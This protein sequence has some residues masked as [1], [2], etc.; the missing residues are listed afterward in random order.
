MALQLLDLPV[1]LL[2]RIMFYL[3]MKSLKA[4]ARV[5]RQL[6][7][8]ASAPVL[9]KHYAMI[10]T[11]MRDASDS[12]VPPDDVLD[13]LNA[14][15]NA[16]RHYKPLCSVTCSVPRNTVGLYELSGGY[17]FLGAAGRRA[18]HYMPLP[19]PSHPTP[20][21]SLLTIGE[22]IVDFALALY[23]H[24]LVVAVTSHP[25]G[26]EGRDVLEIRLIDFPSGRPHPLAKQDRIFLCT[27]P[28]DRHHPFLGIEV[29]GDTMVIAT[30]YS[31]FDD[32]NMPSTL[33]FWD[34]KQGVKKMS[35][36]A[37]KSS[38]TTFI[39]LTEDI[40]LVPNA[41]NGTLEYWRISTT[42][43][44][45]PAPLAVLH[46]PPLRTGVEYLDLACRAEP[47]P[48]ADVPR[49]FPDA[50]PKGARR[51]SVAEQISTAD[52]GRTEPSF[53]PAAED[54]ICVFQVHLMRVMNEANQE[55]ILQ[56][57]LPP[58][59]HLVLVVHRSAF[60][61]ILERLLREPKDAKADANSSAEASSASTAPLTNDSPSSPTTDPAHAEPPSLPWS[62][63][64][65]PVSRWLDYARINYNWITTSC[66]Q[67][68]VATPAPE[69]QFRE[70]A[71]FVEVCDFNPYTVE[72]M[73]EAKQLKKEEARRKVEEMYRL[74]DEILNGT[75]G[76]GIP[77]AK[78]MSQ[79]EIDEEVVRFILREFAPSG[80]TDADSD[81]DEEEPA[82]TGP[83]LVDEPGRMRTLFE[84]RLE[85]QLPYIK[86]T[87]PIPPFYSGVMADHRRII[88]MKQDGGREIEVSCFL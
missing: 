44:R 19:M 45:H 2:I 51:S 5:N 46:L 34:W 63:W 72:K 13:E 58:I 61:E 4:V 66:G 27:S 80:A 21:W 85:S 55:L 59:N 29:V 62:E 42:D 83:V 67:R 76:S 48:R 22:N 43:P 87:S 28:A 31:R 69:I 37:P 36:D 24:N 84:G 75:S 79:E 47:N 38:Y 65:A 10:T 68:M 56:D 15:E 7:V 30:H 53:Y 8:V 88:G 78:E 9:K 81:S 57:G 16:W 70:G 23:E 40:V 73:R 39:F 50:P 74:E 1:E 17:M 12:T 26:Q 25:D 3:D 33:S 52:T 86:T 41:T 20:Q 6:A 32:D 18:L 60:M 64:G 14:Y 77:P 71:G 82:D 11:G 35:F 49:A 54:A